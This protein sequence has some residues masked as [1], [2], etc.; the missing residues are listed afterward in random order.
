MYFVSINIAFNKLFKYVSKNITSY[1]FLYFISMYRKFNKLWE[2]LCFYI[3]KNI[4]SHAFLL[5][6]KIVKSLQC[7]VNITINNRKKR[8]RNQKK[9]NF[10][11]DR[12]T[13]IQWLNYSNIKKLQTSSTDFWLALQNDHVYLKRY[14]SVAIPK[15]CGVQ[16]LLYHWVF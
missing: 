1:A 5:V 9:I 8:K 7:I 11:A 14:I 16:I 6:F 3:S 4:T 2:Y 13:Q 15:C 12:D 10:Y